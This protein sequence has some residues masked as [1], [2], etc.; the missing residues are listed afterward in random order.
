MFMYIRRRR[1]LFVGLLVDIDID[2]EVVASL[3][4]EYKACES[5]NYVNWGMGGGSAGGDGAGAA[6]HGS[7]SG[8]GGKQPAG[9]T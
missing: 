8:S 2:R 5:P 9:A 3:I 4:E 7:G 6:A 1:F